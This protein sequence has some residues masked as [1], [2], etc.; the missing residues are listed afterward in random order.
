MKVDQNSPTIIITGSKSDTEKAKALLDY[1]LGA[2][3]E[4][5][6]REQEIAALSGE[7]RSMGVGN[8]GFF[9]RR[10]NIGGRGR[11]GRGA[12]GIGRGVGGVGFDGSAPQYGNSAPERNARGGYIAARGGRGGRG[13]GNVSVGASQIQSNAGHSGDDGHV[14]SS[15]GRGF[16]GAARPSNGAGATVQRDHGFVVFLGD[17]SARQAPHSQLHHTSQPP[18]QVVSL[19]SCSPIRRVILIL[20]VCVQALQTAPSQL[21]PGQAAAAPTGA[22]LGMQGRGGGAVG[23]A[24]LKL[25]S[26]LI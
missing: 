13:R 26:W 25:V 23:A 7:L 17:S 2:L 9:N 10:G 24:P 19:H 16:S 15:A 8:I 18:R 20:E 14:V 4:Q 5:R 11:F 1:I 6:Q 21:R 22:P 12:G 3:E